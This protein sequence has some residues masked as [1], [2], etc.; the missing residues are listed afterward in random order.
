M[1]V[2]RRLLLGWLQCDALGPVMLR[3]PTDQHGGH[4]RLQVAQGSA[5]SEAEVHLP[6]QLFTGMDKEPLYEYDEV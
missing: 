3:R 5:T 2:R 6:P 1:W 4:T